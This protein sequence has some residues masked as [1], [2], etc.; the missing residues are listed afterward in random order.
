MSGTVVAFII[1]LVV[2][3]ALGLYVLPDY[4]GGLI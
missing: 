1:G 2:G 3:I 4:I